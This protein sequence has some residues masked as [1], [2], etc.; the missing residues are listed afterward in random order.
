MLTSPVV[1]SRKIEQ[2]LDS[3][4]GLRAQGATEQTVT[5]LREALASPTNVIVAKAATIAA[6]L[7]LQ[8]L[9]PDLRHTFHRLFENAARTDPQCWGK[10]A[11]AKALK[12]LGHSASED[13][14]RGLDHIQMEPVWGGEEDTA[15]VLR[16]TCALALVQCADI[17]RL[18]VLRRLV[19]T[20]TDPI[21]TV[22]ADVARALAEM[23]GLEAALLLR[24]K[25]RTGD[26]EPAVT[27]Q[28]LESLLQLE[29]QAAV[30]F[31]AGFLHTRGEV[32]E[33]AALA[34][35]A[36]RLPAAVEILKQTWTNSRVL[37]PED[38]LLRAISSSRQESA[39]EFLLDLVR[40]G[41]A[42]EAV[43]AITALELHRGSPEIQDQ[44]ANAVAGR[45]EA[46]V[47]E[48]FRRSTTPA[49]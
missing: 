8:P 11:I 10:N 38:V 39:I 13:F 32:A 47:Q 21:A 48:R 31:V 49:T 6:A 35:G 36:S 7:A 43:A 24:L 27:G 42:R 23:E 26:R 46:A 16:S 9:V 1:A 45:E 18:E 34:L 41:P 20:F 30:P 33:E 15:T 19:D 40:N 3:L 25:A 22:R 2:Q 29:H 5:A 4:S 14:L 44:L 37:V 28:V 17:T 12:D